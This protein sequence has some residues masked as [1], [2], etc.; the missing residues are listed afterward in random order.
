MET[1]LLSPDSLRKAD[2][3]LPIRPIIII[4]EGKCRVINP[5][6]NFMVIELKRGDVIGESDLLR[7]SVSK[8]CSHNH[9]EL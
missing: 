4:V 3:L 7:L 9:I 2:H 6:D 1:V 5:T 8:G